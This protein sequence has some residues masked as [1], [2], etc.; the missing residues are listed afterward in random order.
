MLRFQGIQISKQLTNKIITRVKSNRYAS[1]ENA[2]AGST[3]SSSLVE[4]ENES[5]PLAV[6]GISEMNIPTLLPLRPKSKI[7]FIQKRRDIENQRRMIATKVERDP[8]YHL[9]G[10]KFAQDAKAKATY[11]EL[12]WKRIWTWTSMTSPF[13]VILAVWYIYNNWELP[14]LGLSGKTDF[15]LE[16]ELDSIALNPTYGKKMF[17]DEMYRKIFKSECLKCFGLETGMIVYNQAVEIVGWKEKKNKRTV[18]K[19]EVVD[20]DEKET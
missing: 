3:S 12:L 6:S 18:V 16:K 2:T 11:E 7:E 10:G 1:N 4:E 13:W 14:A 17:T 15:I 20:N 8:I 5:G 19:K 9:T